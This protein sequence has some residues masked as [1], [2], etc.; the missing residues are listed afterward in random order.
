MPFFV[1]L[2]CFRTRNPQ[3]ED[4]GLGFSV[5]SGVRHFRNTFFSFRNTRTSYCEMSGYY[6]L[7]FWW[8]NLSDL[9]FLC[10]VL[11]IYRYQFSSLDFDYF[12]MSRYIN[13]IL[14]QLFTKV[15]V[16][17]CD[18]LFVVLPDCELSLFPECSTLDDCTT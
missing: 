2:F 5:F 15:A 10:I 9:F 1:S 3:A 13:L 8:N 12:A 11:Q 7:L 4:L 17:L 18:H 16:W 6:S 14:Y